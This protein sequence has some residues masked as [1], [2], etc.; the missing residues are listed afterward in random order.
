MSTSTLVVAGALLP[1]ILLWIAF[2][3]CRARL[4]KRQSPGMRKAVRVLAAASITYLML[5]F[6]GLAFFVGHQRG[7]SGQSLVGALADTFLP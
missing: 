7:A 1:G 4:R 5:L 3:L 6:G 2:D